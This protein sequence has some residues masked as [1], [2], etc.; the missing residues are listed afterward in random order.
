MKLSWRYSPGR[1]WAWWCDMWRCGSGLL[2]QSCEAAGYIPTAAILA[3][4]RPSSPGGK[5]AKQTNLRPRRTTSHDGASPAASDGGV[6]LIS[7]HFRDP[8]PVYPWGRAVIDP[9]PWHK[10]PVCLSVSTRLCMLSLANAR[11]DGPRAPCNASSHCPE[12]AVI[13]N[14][15][16]SVLIP[17][18]HLLVTGVTLPLFR[19]NQK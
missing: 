4:P 1:T 9:G 18:R 11:G 14:I 8:G 5:P 13:T 6:Y 12:V 16:S 7:T 2:R 15:F 3:A 10:P 19:Y 17:S